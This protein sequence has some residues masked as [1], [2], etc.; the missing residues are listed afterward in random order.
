MIVAFDIMPMR[1]YCRTFYLRKEVVEAIVIGVPMS[2]VWILNHLLSF[3]K[4]GKTIIGI[5]FYISFFVCGGVAFADM[6]RGAGDGNI[7]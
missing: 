5:F 3:Y 7:T 6:Q 4:S 2:C 1:L